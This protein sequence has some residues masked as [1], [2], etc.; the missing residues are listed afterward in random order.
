MSVL[1]YEDQALKWQPDNGSAQRFV[2]INIV[3]LAVVLSVGLFLSSIELPKEE[4]MIHVGVP[5]RVA[6]FI[7]ENETPK[8]S[9]SQEAIPKPRPKPKPKL[10]PKVKR[11]QAPKPKIQLKPEITEDNAPLTDPSSAAR[12][13][14]ENSGLLALS[15]DLADLM[16]TA[17]V[18]AMVGRKIRRV[19]GAESMAN[20]D[21]DVLDVG[22]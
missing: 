19:S 13:R 9:V 3:V 18:N 14:A 16:D 7:L 11:E 15:N 1:N 8:P 20:I 17:D 12:E 10:E 6:Q 2:V 21:A 4:R 22:P 5:E